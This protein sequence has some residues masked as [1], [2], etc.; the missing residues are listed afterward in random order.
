M[1]NLALEDSTSPIT[2]TDVNS[3]ADIASE[4][5]SPETTTLAG[6]EE[7][8]GRTYPSWL[9]KLVFVTSICG[10]IWLGMWIWQSSDWHVAGKWTASIC[11][12][13]LLVLFITEA[14]GRIVQSLVTGDR[15]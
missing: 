3:T 5:T 8:I 2:T 14:I 6:R 12:L 7:E 11:G 1:S 4:V 13:P 10:A 9:E 15:A